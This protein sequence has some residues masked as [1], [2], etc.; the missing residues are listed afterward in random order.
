ML[1]RMKLFKHHTLT[2]S[3][4]PL[5]LHSSRNI[6]TRSSA[7]CLSLQSTITL[8]FTVSSFHLMFSSLF[9]EPLAHCI[10][11]AESAPSIT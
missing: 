6:L 3:Y 8:F 5:I 9:N 1:D 10:S 2:I 11:S 7:V 4:F